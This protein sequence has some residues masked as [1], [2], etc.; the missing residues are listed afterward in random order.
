MSKGLMSK[1]TGGRLQRKVEF[2]VVSKGKRSN[3]TPNSVLQIVCVCLGA[4]VLKKKE[5]IQ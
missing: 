2:S 3:L 4:G 5:K 1:I